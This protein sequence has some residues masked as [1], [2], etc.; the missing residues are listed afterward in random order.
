MLYE[1]EVR[2]HAAS[3]TLWLLL[4]TTQ[5]LVTFAE[6]YFNYGSPSDVLAA[7]VCGSITALTWH[8]LIRRWLLRFAMRA[9]NTWPF[10]W[11]GYTTSTND[12]TSLCARARGTR[13]ASTCE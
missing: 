6:L 10:T 13:R 7:L 12:A 4:C 1:C 3:W 5:A 2:P 11:L 9:L 8:W